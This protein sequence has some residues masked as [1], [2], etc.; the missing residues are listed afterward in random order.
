MTEATT[1]LTRAEWLN[2]A[3]DWL[4]RKPAPFIEAVVGSN[5]T[6]ARANHQL[7]MLAAVASFQPRGA[8]T[9]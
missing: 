8:G 1:I 4:N 9:D 3:S 7:A 2:G 5:Q 6:F